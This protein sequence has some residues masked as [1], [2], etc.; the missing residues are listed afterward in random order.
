MC[1]TS[2]HFLICALCFRVCAVLCHRKHKKGVFVHKKGV[3][4]CC[5]RTE[6]P[7]ERPTETH[8]EKHH[9]Q[10]HSFDSLRPRPPGSRPQLKKAACFLSILSCVWQKAGV[11]TR[12]IYTMW[13]ASRGCSP[14]SGEDRRPKSEELGWMCRARPT[15]RHPLGCI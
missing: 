5:F 6:R 9:L 1:P 7:T 11:C 2:K 14:K 15:E 8:P 12:G 4:V 13:A 10:A 3:S